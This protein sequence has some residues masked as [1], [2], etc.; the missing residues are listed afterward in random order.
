MSESEEQLTTLLAGVMKAKAVEHDRIE[1]E[2]REA[3]TRAEAE[4]CSKLARLWMKNNAAGLV[5]QIEAIAIKGG[6]CLR[7]NLCP[8]DRHSDCSGAWYRTFSELKKFFASQGFIV[9]KTPRDAGN[10]SGTLVD[11]LW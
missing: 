3:K 8:D 10:W 1:R 11:I 6:R 5:P 7:F 4:L 9:T 2:L